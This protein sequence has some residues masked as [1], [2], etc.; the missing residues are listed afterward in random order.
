[1]LPVTWR[2]DALTD[3]AE[4]I[5]YIAQRN[6]SAALE[7][8]ELIDQSTSQLPAHPYLYRR[9]LVAGTREMVVHPNYIVIYTVLA[10]SIDIVS[11]LH[12]RQEYPK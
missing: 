11:V 10:D 6:Q 8:A 2:P 4:I 9:G 3:L 12:A 7:L 1:M 5:S